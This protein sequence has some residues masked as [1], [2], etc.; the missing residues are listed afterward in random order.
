[1]NLIKADQV[2]DRHSKSIVMK[3]SPASGIR[4]AIYLLLLVLLAGP[5][6]ERIAAYDEDTHFLIT[7]VMCRAVGF[8]EKE[9][10]V[11][12]AV[13]QGMDDSDATNAHDGAKPRI[14]EEWLWHALDKDGKMGAAGII[15][16]RDALFAEAINEKDPRLR[17]I[18][19]GMFFHYQQDSWAH[20]H[21][22]KD[23]HLSPDKFITF[24]TPAG[25]AEFGPQP[26]R[27]P[28]DPVAALMS[29]TDGVRYASDF[30]THS[31][32]RTPNV[33]FKGYVSAG[34]N[35]DE[36]WKDKRQGKFFNQ[37]DL[38]GLAP[39]SPGLFLASLI[40][41]QID[42][43]PASRSPNPIFFGKNT[44]DKYDMNEM[45]AGMQKVCLLFKSQIGTV[46][47]PSESEKIAQGFTE[48]TSQKLLSLAPGQ[49]LTN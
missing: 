16:R 1:M 31:M 7:Y 22:E 20:R 2:L 34:G 10:L 41:A 30:M 13:D 48:L 18:R 29:L 39:N 33:F 17:L 15:A 32:G 43:Y 25:H 46:T 6:V 49:I 24:N 36:A 27:P 8:T 28:L 12:A 4:T 9:A 21:H 44:A 3:K 45:R 40:R 5:G 37:I 38:T 14:S 42:A 26:D 35:V 23:S 47:L 19:L 11:I